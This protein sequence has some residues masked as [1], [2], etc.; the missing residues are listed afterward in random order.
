[1]P[2]DAHYDRLLAIVNSLPGTAEKR[3]WGD[4]PHWT[5]AGKIFAGWGREGDKSV[6]GVKTEKPMQA[7][8]VAS[9]PRFTIAPYVGK[10]GWVSMAL[11]AKP[12]WDEVEALIL[13]SYRLIAPKKLVAQ[14]AGGAPPAKTAKAAK[15]ARASK[16]AAKTKAKTKARAP[17]AAKAR[18]STKARQGSSRVAKAR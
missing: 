14:I 8:L 1:M 6:L 16:T 2:R 12:N 17:Q 4:E 9:D 7:M 5:V 11:G 10:H 13:G 15:P 18:Q 3:P